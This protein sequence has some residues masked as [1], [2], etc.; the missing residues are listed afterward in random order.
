M[1]TLFRI[2][3]YPTSFMPDLDAIEQRIFT[4]SF[5]FNPIAEFC[6][7]FEE[8]G[9]PIPNQNKKR[10]SP[11]PKTRKRNSPVNNNPRN[12]ELSF[13]FRRVVP[14]KGSSD[15]LLILSYHT[16][17]GRVMSRM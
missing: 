1:L 7:S 12:G 2:M 3:P 13:S 5:K 6:F 8:T 17:P 4:C 10:E 16:P 14:C 9:F 11:L 15:S